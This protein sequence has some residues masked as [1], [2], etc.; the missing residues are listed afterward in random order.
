MN[1]SLLSTTTDTSIVSK[2]TEIN[3]S[4]ES[5]TSRE[6]DLKNHI[7][8]AISLSLNDIINFSR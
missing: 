6:T 5:Q 7:I 3:S 4:Y 1:E 8:S 2:E